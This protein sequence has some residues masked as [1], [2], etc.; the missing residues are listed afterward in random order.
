MPN[1]A[2]LVMDFQNNVVDRLGTPEVLEAAGRAVGAARAAGVPVVF[3]RVAFR[4]GFP[5]V[6]TTNLMFGGMPQRASGLPADPRGTEV[7]AAVAPRGDEPVITKV[8]V[9]IGRAHV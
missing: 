7:H 6:A 3:V 4:P 1:T 9:K 2:L 5:E 8:R